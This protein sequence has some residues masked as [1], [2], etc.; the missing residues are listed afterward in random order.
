MPLPCHIETAVSLL[1]SSRCVFV[2]VKYINIVLSIVPVQLQMCTVTQST[3]GPGLVWWHLQPTTEH[4]HIPFMA[5][6]QDYS[7]EPVPEDIF[8][9][10]FIVQ[11]KITEADTPTS[12][13]GAIPSGLRSD[14]PPSS[15]HFYAGYPFFRCATLPTLSWLGTGTK[16]AGLYAQW[17][18]Y[19]LDH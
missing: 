19:V 1:S 18:G 14:P 12:R 17:R 5:L 8:F 2:W 6:F 10:T 3:W 7:G 11:G 16:Y 13:L 9:W 4:T 15:P